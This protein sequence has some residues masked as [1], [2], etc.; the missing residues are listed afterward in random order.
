MGTPLRPS[1]T[2]MPVFGGDDGRRGAPA[3]GGVLDLSVVEGG[4]GV[5]LVAGPCGAAR[6]AAARS[7]GGVGLALCA[8][9]G[10]EAAAAAG[11]ACGAEAGGGVGRAST[12]GAAA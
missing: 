8:A 11:A 5:D 3:G 9:A 4:T 2:S 6:D 12:S 10:D 1:Q 7:G